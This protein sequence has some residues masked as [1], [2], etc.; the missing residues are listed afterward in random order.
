MLPDTG[1]LRAA[2]PFLAEI[3]GIEAHLGVDLRQDSDS[4]RERTA[5]PNLASKI[6]GF[7][8]DFSNRSLAELMPALSRSDVS[9]LP[10]N[11]LQ[12]RS[13][14]V[15]SRSGV[16]CWSDLAK[17]SPAELG[18][19][20]NAGHQTVQD[21]VHMCVLFA[22]N[23]APRGQHASDSESAPSADSKVPY[24]FDESYLAV[25]E[26]SR[27][28]RS[29]ATWALRERSVV[30]AMAVWQLRPELN[31][32]QFVLDAWDD[33]L[34][35]RLDNLADKDLLY[36]DVGTLAEDLLGSFEA[37]RREVLQARVLA[38]APL[39]LDEIG[40]RLGVSRE[41]VRQI[42]GKVTERL[43]SLL[44]DR[45]FLPLHWRAGDLAQ[46]LGAAAPILA[47]ESEQALLRAVR[48]CPDEL[49]TTLK[50]F[51]LHIAGPY[52]VRDGWYVR[53]GARIPDARELAT[54]ADE[55]GLLSVPAAAE[56][57]TSQ[58]VD[59][60][61][62]DGWISWSGRFQ[63]FG[64][65]LAV[66]SGSVVDKCVSILALK[67]APTDAETLVAEVGEGHNVTG[68]RNRLFEDRRLMRT[69]RSSWGLRAWRLEEYTGITEEIA[70]R[71]EEWGGRAKIT[72]LVDEL[73]RL[74]GVSPG[75]V[76][77]YADAPMFFTED[78]YVQMRRSEECFVVDRDLSRCRGVFRVSES[79]FSYLMAVDRDVLR[80]SGRVCPDGLAAAL[81][82]CPGKPRSF[83]TGR[84]QIKVSWPETSASGPSLGST[85][86]L[87]TDVGAVEGDLLRL[88]FETNRGECAAF[89]V[90]LDA[91]AELTDAEAIKALTGLQ[92]IGDDMAAAVALGVGTESARLG[93]VL[94]QRGDD[95]VADLLP[96]PQ[97][98]DALHDALSDLAGVL[99]D[100]T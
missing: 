43:T 27:Q 28:L 30:E 3:L 55:H 5:W 46:A 92:D 8:L 76:R 91:L 35:T 100:L 14:N 53:L 98:D 59:P 4:I 77:V 48:D 20:R 54:L 29:I 47:Q 18:Q 62:L 82:V 38:T 6:A 40:R 15:L 60:K 90:R 93:E 65:T 19:L 50:A 32:P 44:L 99:N 57:L 73:V 66:W 36:A 58:K 45:K 84:G 12:V 78:G 89:R 1:S 86:A 75:S 22:G 72:D 80:G 9:K 52:A 16:S 95:R 87:A 64:D 33:F 10:T 37:G 63:R 31:A 96:V 11:T 68:V 21:I 13:R 17:L 26:A 61:H 25:D 83:S 85:R 79:S 56:W 7:A 41:R 94:R 39:T 69:G 67:G 34:A 2:Y 97:V 49:A 88:Q 74:F 70:Q 71:I 24:V 81:G 23:D 42:Q 51:L